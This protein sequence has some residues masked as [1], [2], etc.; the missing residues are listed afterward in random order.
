MVM[1]TDDNVLK[2]RLL[3]LRSRLKLVKKLIRNPYECKCGESKT[4]DK[5]NI[6]RCDNCGGAINLKI[7]RGKK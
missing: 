2:A 1:I 6:I 4:T 5:A 7:K 3:V